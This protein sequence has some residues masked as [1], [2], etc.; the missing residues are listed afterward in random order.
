VDDRRIYMRYHRAKVA[1]DAGR[2]LIYERNDEACWLD[3]LEPYGAR[4]P[5]LIG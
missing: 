1:A 3:E 5:R 2:F 4:A